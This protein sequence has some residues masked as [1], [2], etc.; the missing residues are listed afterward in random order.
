MKTNWTESEYRIATITLISPYLLIAFIIVI[1][2]LHDCF[3]EKID[4]MDNSIN[5]NREIVEHLIVNDS[6][7]NGFRVVWATKYA[8]T[9]E[10]LD[11][12]RSR[13][14]IYDAFHRLQVEAPLHFGSLLKTDIYDF[15][16]FA[17]E[18]ESDKDIVI[19]NIFVNGTKKS[20]LYIGPN[21]KIQNPAVYFDFGTE[22]GVLYISHEDIYCRGRGKRK[23]YRYWKCDGINSFSDFDE[24]FS[25]FSEDERIR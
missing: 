13:G 15:A 24:Q 19:H 17:L 7:C 3:G 1:G 16:E 4:P 6:T 2:I 9:K 21:H 25:H 8:V 18:Y 14:H 10:R 20:W 22:Q 5:K 11:E 23:I 12:I